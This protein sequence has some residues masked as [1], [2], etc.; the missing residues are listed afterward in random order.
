MD[1]R[2][3]HFH[4]CA[5]DHAIVPPNDLRLKRFKAGQ[6][7][8]A[9]LP[10]MHAIDGCRR[11]SGNRQVVYDALEAATARCAQLRWNCQL[12]AGRTAIFLCCDLIAILR[13]LHV[14]TLGKIEKR[15]CAF[16]RVCR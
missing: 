3:E 6:G 2:A 4:E 8:P 13:G 15:Q 14:H 10:V 7:E 5:A 1:D 11:K 16:P 9:N 12:G